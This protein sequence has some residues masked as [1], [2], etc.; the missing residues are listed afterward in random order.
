[1]AVSFSST[2]DAAVVDEAT[3]ACE[4]TD[5]ACCRPGSTKHKSFFYVIMF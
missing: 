5:W 4:A 3:D 1:M 2:T